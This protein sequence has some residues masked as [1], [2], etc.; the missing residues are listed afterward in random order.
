MKCGPGDACDTLVRSEMAGLAINPVLS[1]VS[2][3]RGVLLPDRVRALYEQT[4]DSGRLICYPRDLHLGPG[5]KRLAGANRLYV[6]LSGFKPDG[7]IPP[8]EALGNAPRDNRHE[9][10]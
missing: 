10:G 2:G 1:S 8:G 7:V 3:R 5:K 9:P 4:P 6:P